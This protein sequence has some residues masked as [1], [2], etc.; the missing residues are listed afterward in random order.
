MR[1]SVILLVVFVAAT[2]AVVQAAKFTSVWK[3][4]DISTIGFAGKK[5][6]ALVI[7]KDDG[8]RQSAEEALVRQLEAIGVQGEASYRLAPSEVLSD[9]DKAKAWFEKVHVEGVVAMRLVSADKVTTYTPAT[10]TT[11]YYGSLWGYY[12][13][14]WGTAWSPG[15]SSEDTKV[16]VETLIFSVPKDK[17]LWA[18]VS[19]TT[20][21]KNT[22]VFMKDL[23]TKA[24]KEMK[25]Q[26]LTAPPK[27]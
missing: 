26:G 19:E 13:Y 25:K 9:K 6:A 10:F 21:P 7:T 18:G 14:S 12:G 4:P 27:K 1:R 17:L 2:V 16:I 20:N 23:V 22:D 11:G 3:A 24:V 15:Y 8:L 5:V